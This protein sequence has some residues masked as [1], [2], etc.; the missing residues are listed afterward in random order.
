MIVRKGQ[1]NKTTIAEGDIKEIKPLKAGFLLVL[2]GNVEIEI[3]DTEIK[4]LIPE[5]KKLAAKQPARA[6]KFL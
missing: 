4:K 5:V 1:F 6:M 3:A 2:S